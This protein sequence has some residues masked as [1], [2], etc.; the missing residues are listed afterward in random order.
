MVG[1]VGFA[2]ACAL[3][4]TA[5]KMTTPIPPSIVT[6]DTVETRI[7]TLK[8][9]DGFPDAPTAEKLY[10]NLDW[11]RGVEAFLNAMPGASVE[12][13]HIGFASQGADNHTVLITQNP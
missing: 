6:P 4:A 1:A 7:G 10:D 13:L 11:M 2:S 8:F 5:M 9:F 3:A 12:A